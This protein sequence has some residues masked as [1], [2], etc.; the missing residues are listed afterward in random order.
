MYS[1]CIYGTSYKQL[2]MHKQ[3]GH[4]GE[5]KR[6]RLWSMGGLGKYVSKLALNPD[7]SFLA[8]SPLVGTPLLRL[9]LSC[10]FAMELPMK[11]S[12]IVWINEQRP[13]QQQ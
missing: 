7:H 5:V 9:R 11:Q 12:A 6:G 13:R 4:F 10:E 8:T 1:V 3:T 2:C